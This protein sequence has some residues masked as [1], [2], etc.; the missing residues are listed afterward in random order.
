MWRMRTKSKK[1]SEDPTWRQRAIY[2]YK[3]IFSFHSTIKILIGHLF[4]YLIRQVDF[5][6]SLK[7]SAS[8][9]GLIMFR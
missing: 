8:N 9:L 7:L 5:W 1:T 3:F 6:Q 2:L 4:K